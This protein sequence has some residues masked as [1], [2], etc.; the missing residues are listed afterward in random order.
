MLA[1]CGLLLAVYYL[2]LIFPQLTEFF[3]DSAQLLFHCLLSLSGETKA[4]IIQLL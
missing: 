4:P 3:I 1:F 2:V